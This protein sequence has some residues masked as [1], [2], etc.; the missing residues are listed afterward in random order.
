MSS[1]R[2][3]LM[4]NIE[5]H[6]FA[7]NSCFIALYE[8]KI[9]FIF[10]VW[11]DTLKEA[12]IPFKNQF[13]SYIMSPFLRSHVAITE[14]YQTMQNFGILTALPNPILIVDPLQI[15]L[16]YLELLHAE[17]KI[18]LLHIGDPTFKQQ[19]I[20]EARDSDVIIIT[21]STLDLNTFVSHIDLQKIKALNSKLCVY[22]V[23]PCLKESELVYVQPSQILSFDLDKDD[24]SKYIH[25]RLQLLVPDKSR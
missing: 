6:Q 13:Q 16:E 15:S 19:F 4:L 20:T 7:N 18:T 24:I 3:M 10:S 8:S 2:A 25:N 12:N 5:E 11:K 9:K 23:T 22:H 17:E 21:H 14:P 1:F